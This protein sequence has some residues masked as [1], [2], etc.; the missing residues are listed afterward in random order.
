M[1]HLA[2]IQAHSDTDMVKLW[3]SLQRSALTR[4]NY[5]RTV[6]V[7]LSAINKK[8]LATL[9][10]ADL[11][12]WLQSQT[13]A[14]TTLANRLAAIKS[15]FTLA[16]KIGYLRFNPA[17][18]IRLSKA[19]A[20]LSQRILTEADIQLMIIN[21]ASPRNRAILSLLYISGMRISELCALT[22]QD[23]T[24]TSTGAVITVYGKG[25]KTRMI[26]ISQEVS[27]LLGQRNEDA[28][29][30]F[31]SRKFEGHLTRTYATKIVKAAAHR[32]G[33]TRTVSAHWMRH[34]HASHALE[35]GASLVL[36]QKTLGHAS[37]A[38]TGI[39]L[40]ARPEH[41]SGQFL[42]LPK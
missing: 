4:E 6:S 40:H 3:L 14:D 19:K 10:V 8:P 22:W 2:P 5:S 11:Q 20:T 25:S 35:H 16:V 1:N 33:L 36:V 15:L 41:S 9:T 26:P 13:G 37:I 38:T 30:V 23:I 17:Q 42:E 34:A 7:L 39:Y 18:V 31:V 12:S 32:V 24:L 28:K 29:P 21:E 27:A